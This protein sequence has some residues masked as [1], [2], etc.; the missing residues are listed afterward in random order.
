L[1]GIVFEFGYS[2]VFWL[3]PLPLL[4]IFLVPAVKQRRDAL[5]APFF[6]KMVEI[7]GQKPG[8]GVSIAKRQFLQFLILILIWILILGA[9]ASP[10]IV[11][12]PE[13]QIKTARSMM[14]AVD[15]SGSME[16]RDWTIDGERVSRWDAVR[17]IMENFIER[18][19]GDR[20]GLIFFGSQAYLQVPFTRDLQLVNNMLQEVE[21]GM[22]GQRTAIGNAIGRSIRLFEADSTEKKVLI[23]LTDGVD[24]GSE[25]NPVQAATTAAADSIIIYTIGMGDPNSNLFEID[26]K[27]LKEIASVSGGEYFLAIDSEALD[28]VYETIDELEPIEFEDE[29]YRPVKLLY[30][31]PLAG[32]LILAVLH[33][34]ISGII[35]LIRNRKWNNS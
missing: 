24:S 1:E 25:I 32:A 34:L 7:T 27:S 6:Q 3:A 28:K 16:T 13:K 8:K 20:M 14:V 22:A 5:V 30:Y 17:S 15:I 10:Q 33:Q 31:W 29:S 9:L 18:R 23:L 21:V 26:E 35:V 12:E 4:V 19:E 11:G 2:W